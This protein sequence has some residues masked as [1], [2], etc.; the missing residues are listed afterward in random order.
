MSIL[1]QGGISTDIR[2]R[3]FWGWNDGS[4]SKVLALHHQGLSWITSIHN[5]IKGW[6]WW[7]VFNQSSV[8]AG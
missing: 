2:D 5:K 6:A 3:C 7:H 4:A 8:E 1:N